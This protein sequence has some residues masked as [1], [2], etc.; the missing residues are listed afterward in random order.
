VIRDLAAYER[1]RAA[2]E[3]QAIGELGDEDAIAL[4]E[5]LLSS[6]VLAHVDRIDAPRPMGLAR[7][8]GID[9]GR[10]A[11]ARANAVP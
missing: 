6:S 7:A 4:A 5:A 10:L 2:P 9:A 8:L 3:R 1:L 11:S